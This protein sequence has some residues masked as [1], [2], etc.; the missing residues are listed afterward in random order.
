MKNLN[1][2]LR[3]DY[4]IAVVNELAE[5]LGVDTIIA[6]LL[7]ER[8]VTTFEEARCFFRP[9]LD[10]IHNP[11]LMKDMDCAIARINAALDSGERIMVYGDYDVDG[12]SAVALVYSFL[13]A[14]YDNVDFY[15]PDREKEGYGISRLGIERASA[16][17]VK[18]IIA[19]DCG[20][21][22]VEEVD[23]ASSLGIDFIIGD[24]HLPD[25]ELPH[26]VAVL[27]PKR[28]D[29]PYPYKELS[30]CGIGFK[31]IEAFTEQK[32]EV[33][34]CDAPDTLNDEQR[35]L[36][37]QMVSA[38]IS[39]LDLV[40]LS[41]A[42][43]I[44][45]VTGENRILATFGLR[46]INTH[47]RPGIEALLKFGN[48]EPWSESSKATDVVEHSYFSRELTLSDLVFLVGPRL[49]AAGRLCSAFDSVRV[50]LSSN[51]DM[52]MEQARE[53]DNYNNSRKELDSK[54]TETAVQ[55][56]DSH[57]EML[58]L[59]SIVLFD[60]TWHKGV[61]SIVAS[62]LVERYYK[63]TVIFTRSVDNLIVGSARSPKEFDVHQ[64]LEQCS[65]LLE[66]FGGHKCA[67]GVSLRPEHLEEFIRRFE[68]VVAAT[69]PTE[70]PVPEI[71]VDAMVTFDRLTP[72]FLR[73]LKQ[74]APFGPENTMPVFVT[75]RLVNAF[76]MDDRRTRIVGTNH[77][78]FSVIQ[79]DV[80]SQ[81]FPAIA[82]QMGE[83]YQSMLQGSPFSLCYQLEEN[84]WNGRTEMQI[85]VKDIKFDHKK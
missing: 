73:I 36:R 72:K 81:L 69:A 33:R 15:I 46:V 28:A 68:E 79:A 47:P 22:A 71:E 13:S 41:I 57:S 3:E 19:L 78:K 74:F 50:L 40:A 48:I 80:R 6:T 21:K 76:P 84:Y 54:A 2:S 70:P 63:P 45:P 67:A 30:G 20:I 5:S 27:D 38:L 25:E 32:M 37:S 4:D 62:R 12:T 17:G 59:K 35:E 31:I 14:F 58:Q 10:Q 49:N 18:L 44:V 29:C 55:Y 77:L 11:F 82:F 43:D 24:H 7:V 8:G 83:N 56:L 64:A 34:L 51:L 39:Y 16:T 53:I 26:A 42:S 23:Y 1:W 75:Q 60:E 61:V 85:K 66:H 52:A 9:S 65:D